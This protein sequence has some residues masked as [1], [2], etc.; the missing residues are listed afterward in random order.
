MSNR[1][2]LTWQQHSLK[3]GDLDLAWYEAGKGRAVMVLHGGPGH[4]H[5]LMRA[6]AEPLTHQFRCILPDQRGSG[7]SM[8][9]QLDARSLHIDRF[10]EDIETMRVELQLAQLTL[11]GWSWG[12]ALA[13]M[14]A[15]MHPEHVERL[16]LISPGPIPFEFLEVYQAN[17]MRPLTSTERALVQ[18]N[19]T[20]SAAALQ[21]GDADQFRMLYRHRMEIMFR[22]WFYDPDRA[23]QYRET[24]LQTVDPYQ[25]AQ[26]E[27]YIYGSLGE[28]QGWSNLHRLTMPILILYGYQ[29]F[30]PIT[31]AYTLREWVPQAQLMWINKCGHWP[32]LEQT[33]D[34]YSMLDPFLQGKA[35]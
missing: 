7:L 18:E 30:E 27:P 21:A 5:R 22:I 9:S 35:T 34:F 6:L 13:F 17:L 8:L 20:Q 29:D 31:Q 12:A 33:G 16:A 23:V 15:L 25:I 1:H 26:I 28:F 11:V 10:I 14:Y 2:T 32:W 4:D 3:T 24:F 19:Q